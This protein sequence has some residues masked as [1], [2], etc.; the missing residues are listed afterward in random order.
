MKRLMQL[1]NYYKEFMIQ[2]G[3]NQRYNRKINHDPITSIVIFYQY[4]INTDRGFS[5]ITSFEEH[6]KSLFIH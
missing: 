3:I 1:K 5:E 4:I 2:W 6:L